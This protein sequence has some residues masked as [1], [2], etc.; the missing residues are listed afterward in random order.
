[1]VSCLQQ[2][3]MKFKIIN[4]I[5]FVINLAITYGSLTGIFGATN[6]ALSLKFQ[7]LV[8][9]AG[10]AFS[11]WGP[12]FIWEGVF[13]LFQFLPKLSESKVFHA[14]HL[15]WVGVCVAQVTWSIAFAQEIQWLALVCMWSIL[16]CLGMIAYR[17]AQ[18]ADST[19]LEFW[20]LKGPFFLQLGWICAASVVNLNVVIDAAI[21]TILPNVSATILAN[22]TIVDTAGHVL[23]AA[24]ALNPAYF[25]QS[26]ATLLLA[27][28][29]LSLAGLFLLGVVIGTYPSRVN[30]NVIVCGVVSWALGG[31]ASQLREPV[32]K[33]TRMFDTTVIDALSGASAFMSVSMLLL[34]VFLVGKLIF[35]EF[36]R[37]KFPSCADG[38]S[39]TGSM[40]KSLSKNDSIKNT[41]ADMEAGGASP[42]RA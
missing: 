30:G 3:N 7:T 38:H 19:Y 24:Q 33:T 8:T 37:D 22:G 14:I 11:I 40:R 27:A 39:P 21:P 35:D 10:W 20:I 18:L 5:S 25:A 12:I 4:L 29:V 41:A 9:P 26:N 28:A 42:I 34:V 17:V 36:L 2:P 31:V 32:F 16:L 6:T 1:M 13:A 23:T 15:W